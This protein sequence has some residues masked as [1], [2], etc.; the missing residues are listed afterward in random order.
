MRTLRVFRR[1]LAYYRDHR[2]ATLAGGAAAVAAPLISLAAP[3]IVRRAIDAL[4]AGAS[5]ATALPFAALIVA[6]ALASGLL[7]FVQRR[8]LV[9]VSRHLEHRLRVDLYAH[10]LTLPPSFFM[11]ERIGDVMTRMVSDVGAVRLA[12]GPALM[13][14]LSTGTLMIAAVVLM[15]RIDVL[16]TALALAVVPAVAF[17]TRY[18]GSRIHTC[19]GEAQEQLSA[20]T[21]R[22]QEHLVGL[23]V[24]RAFS[25]ERGEQRA[26]AERN[27]AYVT[28]NARL[29]SLQAAF[30]PLLQALIGLSFVVVLG[31][32]GHAVRVNSITLG[33]FVEFN[34][35]LVRLIWPMIAVG[36]VVNLLQ[37]GAASMSRIEA[38]FG[39]A[40]LPTA[41]EQTL[42][43]TGGAAALELRR[44]SFTYPNGREAALR[45]VSLVL[46]AG[47]RVAVVGAV[48]SGKSTLLHLIP[49]LLEPAPGSV[50]LDG[51]DVLEIPLA[52]LRR[53]VALVPQSSFLFSATLR[54]NIALAH[55]QAND[56]EILAAA[57][58]AGLAN[59]LAE[60]PRGLDTLIGERGVTLS[61]GQRQRVAIAR[62]LLTR[63]RL[64]L[65]D[66]CLAAV[67]ASTE[68][69][70]L[71]QLPGTTLLFATHRLAAAELC[72][73]VVVLERGEVVEAGPPAEL[74]RRGGR[75]AHLLALQRLDRLESDPPP[76]R[77]ASYVASGNTRASPIPKSH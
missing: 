52:E 36:Y 61:G 54:E 41:D 66:D 8:L 50:L 21:A 12:V 18:F 23:R 13:Y 63:P 56:E 27:R 38:L 29:I 51:R 60:M 34:L 75:Y 11:R 35:Y 5:A 70:I 64:L 10:L 62:A 9:G 15:I 3:G 45:D 30:H 28:A 31:V 76:R 43:S 77:A 65:L 72:H 57:Y 48:G 16:L 42:S 68:Q 39:E 26:L 55:P 67:D 17:A 24:L 19:W 59:D 2:G 1:V 49:R 7:M 37:R 58:A 47:E 20:Y 22:L 4:V 32:G 40:S 14:T 46:A 25:C 33:Q 71:Q 6:V 69:L 53:S 44:A 73:R 74:A